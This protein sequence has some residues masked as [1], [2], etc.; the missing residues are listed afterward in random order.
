EGCEPTNY[1]EAISSPECDKWVVA[2]EEEVETLHKNKT[3]E[4]VK[5]P[6]EKCNTPKK[7]VAS[8][9]CPGALLHNAQR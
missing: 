4:L 5:L 1:F 3:W 2:M 9:I 8:E 7:R 6:K